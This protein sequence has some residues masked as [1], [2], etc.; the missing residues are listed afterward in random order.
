MLEED[1]SMET[2][3]SLFQHPLVSNDAT[4][5]GFDAYIALQTQ[6]SI[7]SDNITDKDVT[8]SSASTMADTKLC[9]KRQLVQNLVPILI[10]YVILAAN[11]NPVSAIEVQVVI[12][13]AISMHYCSELFCIYG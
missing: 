13:Q 2:F 11:H 12:V 3:A 5:P 4:N 1:M 6:T 8:A 10:G 9:I 7:P